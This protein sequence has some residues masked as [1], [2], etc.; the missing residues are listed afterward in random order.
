MAQTLLDTLVGLGV[1]AG[2]GI[3]VYCRFMD[4][5]LLDVFIEFREM[6]STQTEEVAMGW[7]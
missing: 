2:L 3:L 4:K 1:I 7:T 5:T 6:F